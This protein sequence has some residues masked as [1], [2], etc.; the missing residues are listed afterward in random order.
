MSD[1]PIFKILRVMTHECDICV[2]NDMPDKGNRAR[3]HAFCYIRRP[4]RK[5][6]S[7]KNQNIIKKNALKL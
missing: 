7:P 6:L 1:W 2:K 4:R 3:R 5:E